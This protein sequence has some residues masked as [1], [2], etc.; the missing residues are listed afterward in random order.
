MKADFLATEVTRAIRLATSPDKPKVRI[1]LVMSPAST[2][3]LWVDTFHLFLNTI[4]LE[5]LR[6]GEQSAESQIPPSHTAKRQR[7]L[8]PRTAHKRQS[9]PRTLHR[10]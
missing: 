6:H 10:R 4:G 3:F 8:T 2:L 5:R 1:S 9:A 7:K